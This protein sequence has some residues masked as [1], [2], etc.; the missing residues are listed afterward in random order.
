MNE[1]QKVILEIYKA[2][3]EIC[4]AHEI[5]YYAVGGTCIGAV[6]H[7]GFIPWDDDLDIAVPIEQY[8]FLCD[9]LKR[10]LPEYY[11]LRT[12]YEVK[13]TSY[14]F[15]KVVDKR[16]TYIEETE[17]D[18][19]DAYK[20]IFVDIM[21]I[22]GIPSQKAAKLWFEYRLVAF[23]LL[24]YLLRWGSDVRGNTAWI[25]LSKIVCR[26]HRK[27]YRYYS[28]KWMDML[29]RHPFEPAAVTGY[30]WWSTLKRK[31]LSYPKR[32]FDKTIDVSFEDTT[33]KCPAKYDK[34]LTAQFGDYMKLPPVTMQ[35]SNHHGVC[36][37]NTSYLYYKTHRKA[38]GRIIQNYVEKERSE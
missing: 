6:R 31:K 2:V 18:H 36:D 34:Y 15:S 14:I 5:V 33:I 17:F 11:A 1:I 28:D 19:P 27:N 13:H 35:Q 29:K 37:L 4:D 30:T 32:W 38:F 16:T 20:G 9:C 23:S 7:N 25:I 24:N 10:E 21:P 3:K 26:L 8:D 12:C 22:S